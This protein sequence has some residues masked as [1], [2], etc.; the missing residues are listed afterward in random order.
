MFRI[1][2]PLLLNELHLDQVHGCQVGSGLSEERVCGHQSDL[3]LSPLGRCRLHD[4]WRKDDILD[5]SLDIS[6]T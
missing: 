5:A 1:H 3:G 4:E 6:L 2:V